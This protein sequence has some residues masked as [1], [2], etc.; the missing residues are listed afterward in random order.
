MLAWAG[1]ILGAKRTIHRIEP[2]FDLDLDRFGPSDYQKVI[3]ALRAVERR[4]QAV[5]AD[6]RGMRWIHLRDTVL[7]SGERQ[8]ARPYDDFVAR[9]P[10]DHVGQFYRDALGVATTVAGRDE[11]GRPLQQ[12]VRVLALP[13]PNY[14]ALLGKEELDVYKLE[15]IDYG[16]DEQRVWMLTVHSPNGSAVCDDGYVSFRRTPH[17]TAV[18]FLACQNFP[19]P[20]LMA[21]T[22]MDRWRWLKTVVTESAYR[23]FCVV[24]MKNIEDCYLGNDFRVG[25]PADRAHLAASPPHRGAWI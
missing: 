2:S 23:R 20:P 10:I 22:R 18:T 21:L 15:Q 19:I 25:R 8:F 5:P 7:F 17:G 4:L 12:G 24:M 9:V 14:T 11:R 3:P 13:Q 6:A 16:P 1:Q